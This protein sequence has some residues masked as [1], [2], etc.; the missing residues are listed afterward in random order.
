MWSD[1]TYLFASLRT[2]I[3]ESGVLFLI[4][5]WYDFCL[6]IGEKQKVFVKNNKNNTKLNCIIYN[7]SV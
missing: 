6:F 7:V 2:K 4:P 5:I 3:S 1:T